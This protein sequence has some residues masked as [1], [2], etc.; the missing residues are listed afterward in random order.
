MH[1]RWQPFLQGRTCCPE[2][3]GCGQL[4]QDQPQLQRAA[5]LNSP[6][7]WTACVQGLRAAEGEDQAILLCCRTMLSFCRAC[8][9]FQLCLCP[10]LLFHPL[11]HAV[12]SEDILHPELHFSICF[13]RAQAVIFNYHVA[14]ARWL[15]FSSHSWF[16]SSNSPLLFHIESWY[17]ISI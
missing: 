5:S 1:V 12:I 10:M 14:G 3:W 7:S 16:V 9:P 13:W 4:C 17:Y 2:A 8:I 11:S 6:S 15:F